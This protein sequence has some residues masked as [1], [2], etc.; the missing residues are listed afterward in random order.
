VAAKEVEEVSDV[1]DVVDREDVA[2]FKS[3]VLIN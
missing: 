1:T 3:G 2:G